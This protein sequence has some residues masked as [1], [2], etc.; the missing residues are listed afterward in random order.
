MEGTM[1]A[2]KVIDAL[3]HENDISMRIVKVQSNPILISSDPDQTINHYRC[4]LFKPG[5]QMDV[6]L[7]LHSVDDLLTLEDVLFMLAMDATSCQL[8]EGYDEQK[9]EW[10]AVFG[11]S[12]GNLEEIN[13]F[14]HE[15]AGRC[16][17]VEKLKNFLGKAA[18]EEVMR[19]M[20]LGEGIAGML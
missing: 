4:Q 20:S 2:A 18:Y 7:S 1:K 16:Q 6:Y 15:Y 3:I 5:K 17:Q 12:D 10:T 11:G 9:D 14:W 13:D 8:L 19:H